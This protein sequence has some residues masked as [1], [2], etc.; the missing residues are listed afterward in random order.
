M[1]V[2][3]RLQLDVLLGPSS[4]DAKRLCMATS[5]HRCFERPPIFQLSQEP[6]DEI[7][8]DTPELEDLMSL[9][10][11]CQVFRPRCEK[12]LFTSVRFSDIAVRRGKRA[13]RGQEFI[14]IL[15]RKPYIASYV[16]ELQVGVE[17][18]DQAWIV[19][20]PGFLRIMDLIRQSAARSPLKKARIEG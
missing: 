8:D 9:S 14:D 18:R 7:I 16:Q 10:L 13:K 3:E 11:V 4:L 20:D 12:H 17:G 19:E 15:S 2:Y 5:S 1:S 6:I